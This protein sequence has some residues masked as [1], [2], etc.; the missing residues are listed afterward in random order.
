MIPVRSQQKN[1]VSLYNIDRAQTYEM[2]ILT[3]FSLEESLSS[4]GM[5]INSEEALAMTSIAGGDLQEIHSF[6]SICSL[7]TNP[8]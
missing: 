5:S 8:T 3:E 6:T 1:W 2:F 7:L 4:M